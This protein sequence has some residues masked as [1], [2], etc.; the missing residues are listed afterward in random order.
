MSLLI[1]MQLFIELLQ[2]L[3]KQYMRKPSNCLN[4]E[5]ILIKL[6]KFSLYIRWVD[7]RKQQQKTRKLS[8]D[9]SL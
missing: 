6:C 7:S 4:Y 5:C 8:E 2:I 9:Q 3:K 1:Y